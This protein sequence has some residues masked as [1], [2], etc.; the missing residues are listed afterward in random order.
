MTTKKTIDPRIKE[1][2][3]DRQAEII[4]MVNKCESQGEAARKL[5]IA[6][7][8]LR[9]AIN[10]VKLKAT[11]A[12]YA[13]E[14]DYTHEV[15]DG[16]MLKGVSTYYAADGMKAGQWVKSSVD[17]ERQHQILRS[18]IETLSATIP[19]QN[20]IPSPNKCIEDLCNL[21]TFTDYHLGQLSWH[22]EGGADWDLKIAEKMLW[23]SLHYMVTHAP[24]AKYCVLNIQGDFL[25]TD[26]L[27]PLTPA[28]KHVLDAD[29]RF[30]K[31][32]DTAVMILRKL[33]NFLLETHEGVHVVFVEGNH[34][35]VSELWL[36]KMFTALYENEPRLTVNNSEIPYYAF[37]FG[38]VMLAFHHGHKIK[39]EALP[40]LFAAQFPSIWGMTKKRYAHCGHR[41]HVD[42]KEYS[43]MIVTQ[44]QT[45]AARDAHSARG[46]WISDR[47]ASLI[48]YHRTFGQFSR[49]FA[50]PEMF[51]T[52]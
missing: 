21:I 37:Q 35:E 22:K 33:I 39:N 1:W 52:A 24:R 9:E 17:I 47:A 19:K 18:A 16:Y 48:T 30:S 5:K 49:T 8:T 41:H 29:G 26:G 14:Y 38:D 7:S 10:S 34:D 31:I 3:T 4:D 28:H 25:H 2:A 40:M 20:P 43:G 23:D 6:E 11:K 32:V 15:P 50:C 12:G 46:G 42:E 27:L 51:T 13:P 44:H 45:L 36:R